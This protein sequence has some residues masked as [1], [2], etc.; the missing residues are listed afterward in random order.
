[1]SIFRF[2][3]PM[4]LQ[5]FRVNPFHTFLSILG[6]IIGVGAL[7]SILSLAD[8]MEQMARNQITSTSNLQSIGIVPKN[9]EF[10][11]GIR[12]QKDSFEI[13]DFKNARQLESQ[14][15]G[16]TLQMRNT[17]NAFVSIPGDT[18]VVGTSIM[19]ILN[20]QEEIFGK[21]EF[22]SGA[23]FSQTDIDNNIP[24]IVISKNISEK[25]F[26]LLSTELIIG[27]VVT[28]DQKEFIISGI[29]QPE[30]A[31]KLG[32]PPHIAMV[33]IT[34]YDNSEL[35][36]HMGTIQIDVQDI[37]S[38]ESEKEKITTF[39]DNN[40]I[41][42]S[43]AFTIISYAD[44][45][46][47]LSQGLLAVKI[48]MGLIVGIS[49]VVGGIGI[50]NVLLMSI[51]E[52]TKEIGIR[53]ALGASQTSI[54]SQFLVE[55]MIISLM[56]CTLGVIFGILFM[57]VAVPILQHFVEIPFSW[58]FSTTNTLVII[59]VALLI[60]IVFGTYPAI[61]AARLDPIEA[62]RHE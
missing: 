42:G 11:D 14:L 62:I 3:V 39:L 13:F 47:Q 60:A 41:G 15:D 31:P 9:I 12:I 40:F 18:V 16:S 50:M 44:R 4:A 7:F 61:K 59:V 48:I 34:I 32:Q 25:L 43:S 10:V 46:K 24:R 8:G 6:I 27:K 5:S 29:C 21:Y 57:S 33:P 23:P 17:R 37:E 2:I 49:V 35:R 36:R 19:G 1:M 52:R 28:Y 56:G 38:F 51:K 30:E 22:I 58:V 26:P 55:A 45:M 53:K 54:K 20:M